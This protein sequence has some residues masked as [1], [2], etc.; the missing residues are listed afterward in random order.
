VSGNPGGRPKIR[1]LSE[2]F[3][4]ELA[5]VDPDDP[6][7]RTNAEM[8]AARTIALAKS[9]ETGAIAAVKELADRTEGKAKQNV[10]LSF[11]QRG[12]EY[13]G[14]IDQI[15]Q[16]AKAKGLKATREEVIAGLEI[17]FP[18]IRDYL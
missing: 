15:L 6:E 13:D 7:G 4:R 1:L 16:E 11:N 3:R 8:I 14:R 9:G 12:K 18:D 10:D 2:A 5:A 17:H